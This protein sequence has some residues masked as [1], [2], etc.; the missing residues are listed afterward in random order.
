MT[1]AEVGALLAAAV[2]GA[3]VLEE[4]GAVTVTV[5]AQSWLEAARTARDDPRLA[6]TFFDFLTAVDEQDAGF[7][8]VLHSY[9]LEHRHH[10]MLRTIVARENPRLASLTGL[11]P[12]A[13]WHERETWEMYGVVFEGHPNLV[14]LLLPD[15][16]EGYPLRKEFV[17][18]ARAA[19]AWPG[20]KEPGE[21]S[22]RRPALAPGQPGPDSGWPRPA[23]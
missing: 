12:G 19:K 6:T 3:Q 17:L 20:A 1:P 10:V 23:P 18:A 9:S 5:P 2:P 15:G 8:V 21:D 11:F 16:F 7:S 13:S 22:P 4:F 14:S